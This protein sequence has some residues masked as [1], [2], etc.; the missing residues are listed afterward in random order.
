MIFGIDDL[1]S[2]LFSNLPTE[3][4]KIV[5]ILLKNLIK[6]KNFFYFLILIK[7]FYLLRLT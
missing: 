6:F 4:F 2:K 5:V 1:F 7:F 3:N